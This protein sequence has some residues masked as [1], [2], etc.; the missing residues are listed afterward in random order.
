MIGN[1][2]EWSNKGITTLRFYLRVNTG[3]SSYI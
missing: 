1:F 2:K 3:P